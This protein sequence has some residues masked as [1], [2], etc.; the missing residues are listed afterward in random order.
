MAVQKRNPAGVG[1]AVRQLTAWVA[2]PDWS[3]I[4][5]AYARCVRITRDPA[6]PPYPVDPSLLSTPA[7]QTLLSALETA[8]QTLFVVSAGK[9]PASP[10][11]SGS[12]A[13]PSSAAAKA[14]PA[15][16]T[17]ASG[18]P[19][20][21]VDALLTA[22]LPLIPP[23]NAFFEA[24][25]VMDEDPALRATRLGLL[26]RISALAAPTVDLSLLEGF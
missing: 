13:A 18:T 12:P 24:V 16:S 6:L 11:S 4:L 17:A 5:P 1:R 20:A 21:S 8:E 10:V 3:L 26:Q 22:F 15:S 2:R 23:I 9:A 25:M 7:E 14:H 19:A